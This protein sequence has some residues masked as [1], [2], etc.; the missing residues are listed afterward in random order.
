MTLEEARLLML[1]TLAATPTVLVDVFSEP[2]QGSGGD[3]IYTVE[4]VNEEGTRW[5]GI[6][7]KSL[8]AEPLLLVT[9]LRRQF[10]APPAL[11]A[12]AG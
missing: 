8:D 3:R 9:E 2:I 12:P 11:P 10:A 6:H 7:S 5:F 1:A 4:L